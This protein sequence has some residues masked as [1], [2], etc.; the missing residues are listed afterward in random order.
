MNFTLQL[1]NL[2]TWLGARFR[3][4]RRSAVLYLIDD[5]IGDGL[6]GTVCQAGLACGDGTREEMRFGSPKYTRIV[7]VDKRA[8][9]EF[10]DLR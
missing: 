3:S 4:R 5:A 1:A 9:D 2:R 7:K 10:A 6:A 8:H